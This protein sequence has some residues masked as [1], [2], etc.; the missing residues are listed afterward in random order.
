MGDAKRQEVADEKAKE[1]EREMKKKEA[2]QAH[3][4]ILRKQ[5]EEKQAQ[6]PRAKVARSQMTDIERSFNRERLQRACN[7]NH[8]AG[9]PMLLQKKR[10][11][12]LQMQK[13]NPI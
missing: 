9:L 4:E 1:L 5:I 7:A 10:E 12:Y 6:G 13:V 11:E 2:Q 3:A 8:P